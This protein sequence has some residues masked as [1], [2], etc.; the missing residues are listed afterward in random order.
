LRDRERE[1]Y[2]VLKEGEAYQRERECVKLTILEGER[3]M[4]EQSFR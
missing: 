4:E 2:T 1:K 3:S